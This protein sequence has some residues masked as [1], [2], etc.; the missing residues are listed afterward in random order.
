MA[1]GDDRTNGSS[2]VSV[3]ME[4]PSDI[5]TRI[6]GIDLGKWYVEDG[7]WH[8]LTVRVDDQGE[9]EAWIDSKPLGDARIK[10]KA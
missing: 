6:H 3:Y 10:E 9:V 7:V 4:Q 8:R 2:M 1:H 5:G